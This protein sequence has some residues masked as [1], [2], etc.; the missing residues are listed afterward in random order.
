MSDK[1]KKELIS[2]I[3]K[4]YAFAQAFSS[5]NLKDVSDLKINTDNTN[6]EMLDIQ[7]RLV[8]K[9]SVVLSHQHSSKFFNVLY[10]DIKKEY[11]LFS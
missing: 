8:E 1:E 10:H 3:L 11:E 9:S 4:M 2:K 7:Y 6:P 5:F